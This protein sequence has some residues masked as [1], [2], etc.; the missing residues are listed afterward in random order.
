MWRRSAAPVAVRSVL[1]ALPQDFV[2]PILSGPLR[3]K[4]W[5]VRSSFESCWLGVYEK[6]KQTAFIAA[7]RPNAIVYDVGANVGFYTLLASVRAGAGGRIVA[8]EPLPR[9]L[10]ILRR[11]VALNRA[12]NV[13][14][15]A[16]AVTDRPGVARF[17]N[18]SI[19]EMARLSDHGE[20]EVQTFQLDEMIEAGRIAPPDILKI[21]VEGAE[22]GVLQGAQRM[23]TRSRPI[24]LLA[25][26]G[27]EVHKLCCELLHHMAYDMRALDGQPLESASEVY[28][29]PR[30]NK[31]QS[32]GRK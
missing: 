28:A 10:Q 2:L 3:G 11:H 24:I 1:K 30:A 32:T 29:A 31:G 4:R 16:G 23:L 20:I 12:V 21:D 17:V 22:F 18:S 19:P 7:I 13:D 15:F 8:F 5:I 27:A 26:H 25:T 14:I 6:E 9:N